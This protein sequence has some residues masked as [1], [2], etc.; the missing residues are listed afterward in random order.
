MDL[1]IIFYLSRKDYGAETLFM[2][3]YYSFSYDIFSSVF[4]SEHRRSQRLNKDRTLSV[5]ARAIVTLLERRMPHF[6]TLLMTR[7]FRTKNVRIY[8]SLHE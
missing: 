6:V 1:L 4:Y 2:R 5:F 8:S 7:A 3:G